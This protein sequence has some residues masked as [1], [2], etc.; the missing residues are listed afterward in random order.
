LSFGSLFYTQSEDFM[1]SVNDAYEAYRTDST[2]ENYAR[3]YDA[4]REYSQNLAISVIPTADRTYYFHAA[5][6]AATNSLLELEKFDLQKA[7][8]ST[9]A[10]MSI[11]RDLIDWARKRERRREDNLAK[12]DSDSSKPTDAISVVEANLM[13]EKFLSTLSEEERTLCEL[14]KKGWALHRMAYKLGISLAT[15]KRRWDGIR[16]KGRNALVG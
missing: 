16:E 3:L 5:E 7:S 1:A 13:L 6:N 15:V 2:D 12:V 10:H 11:K 9:W 8:F 4:L 14:M